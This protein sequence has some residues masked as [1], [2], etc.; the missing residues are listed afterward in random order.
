MLPYIKNVYLREAV[1]F[2]FGTVVLY[3]LLSYGTPGGA[4]SLAWGLAL[5]LSAVLTIHSSAL[6]MDCLHTQRRSFQHRELSALTEEI[7]ERLAT[8][9]IAPSFPLHDNE[10]DIPINDDETILSVR[11]T[12]SSYYCFIST[13]KV[14][15]Y[16]YDDEVTTVQHV[17][18]SYQ[19]PL[20][21]LQGYP[22]ASYKEWTERDDDIE[23]TGTGFIEGLRAGFKE[24]SR[25]H[26]ATPEDLWILYNYLRESS[27]HP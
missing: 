9:G 2:V 17:R 1:L 5:L 21:A 13:E 16:D 12:A 20:G 19:L 26:T 24:A 15:D 4:L 23:S 27:Y 18:R 25:W 10:Q 7:L 14:I 8:H 22:K 11:R 6:L 3:T